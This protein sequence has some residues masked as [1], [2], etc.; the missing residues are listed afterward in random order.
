MLIQALTA[1]ATVGS[2]LT[3]TLATPLTK[4]TDPVASTTCNGKTYVYEELAGYGLLPSDFRDK[5]GDTLGGIGSSIA[6]DLTTWKK[7]G[8]KHKSHDSKGDTYTGILYAIPDRGWN[9]QGTQNTQSR[10]QKLAITLEVVDSA[11]VEK[12]ASPNLKIKY[13]DT[14]LL[15]GP[16]GTPCTGLD[17]DAHGH[18]SFPGFPDL[19]VATYEGDG[20][21]GPGPGGKRISVD[22]EGLV[23]ADDGSFWI[24]DEYG[25]YVYHFDRKGKMVG[26]IR[27]PD[28]FIPVR[29]GTER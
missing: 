26:A 7:K 6:L 15:T 24:S 9:T 2:L 13:L 8:P 22:A 27:P 28:A 20:F 21:G 16:D 3:P 14:I 5:T 4:H 11:T 1:L 18:A 29:N 12:P 17:A 10:I 19:P 25:P 23:L